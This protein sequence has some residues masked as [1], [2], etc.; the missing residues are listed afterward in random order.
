M[1]DC[2]RTRA[3]RVIS[4]TVELDAKRHG[5]EVCSDALPVSAVIM[6]QVDPV[7]AVSDRHRAPRRQFIVHLEGEVEVEASD[8]ER[9]R[10]GPGDVVLVEDVAGRGHVTRALSTGPRR[11]LYLPLTD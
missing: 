2:T 3:A 1:S 5:A 9:R 11:T 8:G 10:F 7:R 4:R 6:R